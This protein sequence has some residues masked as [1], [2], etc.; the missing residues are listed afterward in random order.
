MNSH[1]LSSLI[2]FAED[3]PAN[4]GGMS[5]I[6]SIL[7]FLL[8]GLLFYFMLIR[9]Q[10]REQSRRQ[11]ML[12]NVKK[13]DRVVTIGGIYGVVMNVHREADEVSLKVDETT[14]TKL[15]ITLSSIARV[16]S[17]EPAEEESSK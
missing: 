3:K 10:R 14:N 1:W 2:L 6:F 5:P 9:P 12:A 16:I 4:D 13:N 11:D 17:G 15:R 7:P 8:I